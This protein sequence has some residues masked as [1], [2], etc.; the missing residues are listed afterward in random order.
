MSET[1][2]V[3]WQPAPSFGARWSNAEQKSPLQNVSS[4]RRVIPRDLEQRLLADV[5]HLG[6]EELL[7]LCQVDIAEVHGDVAFNDLIDRLQDLH[8]DGVVGFIE[9]FE[10]ARTRTPSV[11]GSRPPWKFWNGQGY[12]GTARRGGIELEAVETKVGADGCH[13]RAFLVEQAWMPHEDLPFGILE[14]RLP[15]DGGLD[16][17]TPGW[18]EHQHGNSVLGVLCAKDDYDRVRGITPKLK[19]PRVVPFARTAE[20]KT[21]EETNLFTAI[22]YAIAAAERG[23]LVVVAAEAC[24]H[25]DSDVGH[26]STGYLG[27]EAWHTARC[28][29]RI[30]SRKCV[31][32]VTSAGNGPNAALDPHVTNTSPALVVGGGEPRSTRKVASSNHG[33]RVDLHSWGR[34]VVT[35]GP[36]EVVDNFHGTSSATAIVAGVVAV[37]ASHFRA[38]TGDFAEPEKLFRL[39]KCTGYWSTPG[40]GVRPHLGRAIEAIEKAKYDLD[41]ACDG[42]S[43]R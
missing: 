22:A 19:P 20:S 4:P 18:R 5:S 33:Q 43:V 25:F 42:A 41:L 12:L 36:R 28:L 24:K 2:K 40:I 3:L 21:V 23:D 7:R 13:V 17:L 27:L 30:A 31:Y 6:G 38:V 14:L 10:D 34:K 11:Y 1:R 16:L 39:L 37:V 35:L 29:F 32:V 26:L 15:T 9:S 8:R